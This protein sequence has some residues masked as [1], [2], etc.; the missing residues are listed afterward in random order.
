[1]TGFE[2]VRHPLRIPKEVRHLSLEA[3]IHHSMEILDRYFVAVASNF[4]NQVTSAL[5]GGYDSRLIL[6]LLRR[7][8][9][10]PQLYVYGPQSDPEVSL[11]RAIAN[12]EGFALEAL[13]KDRELVFGPDEFGEVAHKNFL[14]ADGYSW[15]G[16]FNNG[17]EAD[18]RAY[19]VRGNS[20]ALNGGGGE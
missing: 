14:A 5:S 2:I 7:H 12:G 18:Q 1:R 17:V 10:Q 6:A 3:S 15:A 11:A 9:V 13:D 8:G 16:I 20:I 19:R 4:G